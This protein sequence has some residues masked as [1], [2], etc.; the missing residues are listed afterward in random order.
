MKL[1]IDFSNLDAALIEIERKATQDVKA[2][3]KVYLEYS[4]DDITPKQ[5]RALHVW[6][7]LCAEHLNTAGFH[8]LSPVSGKRIPW[9]LTAFKED[10]YKPVLKALTD[11]DST[12]KQS[13]VDPNEIREAITAH[14]ATGY[15]E[16]VILPEWPS[17]RG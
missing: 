13:T 2:G 3:K 12:K 11:K 17:N 9:T 15:K 10:V 4:T 5:F 8:R 6:C 16:T 7:K 14:M 1:K